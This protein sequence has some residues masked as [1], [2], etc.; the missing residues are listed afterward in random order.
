MLNTLRTSSFEQWRC[1]CGAEAG[2]PSCTAGS[3][4][5]WWWL[6]QRQ[7]RPT[8]RGTAGS[9][10]WHRPC[11]SLALLG[12]PGLYGHNWMKPCKMSKWISFTKPQQF[13][14]R[15]SRISIGGR[16]I[17]HIPDG[18]QNGRG[19]EHWADKVPVGCVVLIH[20]VDPGVHS[21]SQDGLVVCE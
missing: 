13:C 17:F 4:C 2:W 3:S 5:W 15:Q 16:I 10:W 14:S 11:R 21:V 8:R 9:R 19:E 7:C 18:C 1:I 20:H 12:S 6:V